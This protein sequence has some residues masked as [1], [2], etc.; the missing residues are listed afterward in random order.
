M[1]KNAPFWALKSKN[2]R[3]EGDAMLHIPP[4]LTSQ[5]IPLSILTVTIQFNWKSST[6]HAPKL[7]FSSSKSENFSAEGAPRTLP[8]SAPSAP[9]SS[10]LRR[11]ILS[12]TALDT[13]AK[14][15]R[16]PNL[17][18][19]SPPLSVTKFDAIHNEF[20]HTRTVV[21]T[22]LESGFSHPHQSYT[23]Y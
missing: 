13:R 20:R 15:A 11:S 1:H 8:P 4:K 10:R 17:Q 12:P 7:T 5:C 19:K 21:W 23:V 6:Q 2:F 3:T 16:P 18:H 14:G 22:P 9:R